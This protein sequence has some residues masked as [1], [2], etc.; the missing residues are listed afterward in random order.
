[1]SPAEVRMVIQELT[2]GDCILDNAG[3]MK[4]E[5]GTVVAAPS[6]VHR[7]G[8]VLGGVSFKRGGAPKG[9]HTVLADARWTETTLEWHQRSP[10]P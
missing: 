9:V 3:R 1:M 4:L 8:P 10:A 2:L 6:V 5:D 7:S